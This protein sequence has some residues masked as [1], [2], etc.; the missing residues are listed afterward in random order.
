MFGRSFKLFTLFGFEVKIDVSW[1]IIAVL[2]TW[3]LAAGFFPYLYKNFSTE[4]YWVMGVIGA[5][6]LFLSVIFHEFCHSLVARRLGLPMK[7]ITLFIFGGVAEMSDEPPSAKVEFLMAIAG[8]LSSLLIALV[9]YLIYLGG[10]SAEWPLPVNGVLRYLAYINVL[11]AIFNILPAFPLDGGRVL[12][13]ILWGIKKDLRWATRVSAAVG[14]IFGIFLIVMGIFQFIGGNFIAGLWWFLIGLFIR[15]AAQM[16]YQQVLV[17]NALKGESVRR[18]MNTD[19]ISAPSSITLE[20]LVEDYIYKYHYKMFPV[21]ADGHLS[22]CISTRQVK[23]VPRE[24]WS[25]ETV[26]QFANQCSLDNTV[27][28]DTDALKALAMM[29]KTGNSRLLV[30]EGGKLVGV[31]TLRDMMQFLSL[32]VE[33]EQEQ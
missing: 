2:V 31:L 5:L 9:C 19:P 10:T 15:N 30:V 12:R 3:S 33:L 13:S 16:S 28:P 8:P 24:K 18:F 29:N 6:G 11:L 20:Q 17:R 25:Q 23:E 27:S 32:K 7:G 14:S 1:I 26:G 4:T 21:L 22:G